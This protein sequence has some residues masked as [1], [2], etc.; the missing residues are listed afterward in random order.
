MIKAVAILV[1][2]E[3]RSCKYNVDIIPGVCR[4]KNS[5]VIDVYIVKVNAKWDG[6]V[7]DFTLLVTWAHKV[8]VPSL[9]IK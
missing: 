8:L 2:W 9:S 7:R 5:F 4:P 3:T 1:S 6:N